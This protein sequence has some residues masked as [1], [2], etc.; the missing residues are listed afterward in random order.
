MYPSFCG[1]MGFAGWLTMLVLWT[2]LVALVVWVVAKL[3]PG[4]APSPANP[5]GPGAP[6]QHLTGQWQRDGEAG[7]GAWAS[8]A[9]G[10]S[11][12]MGG[13]DGARRVAFD[14]GC[15]CGL[16]GGVI[17]AKSG[18]DAAVD[19]YGDKHQQCD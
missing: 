15:S 17:E 4:Q 19:E 3:F 11:S 1:E 8:A 18:V 12:A 10:D 5:P 16:V 7:A 14:A 9:G 6:L 2:G 13:D